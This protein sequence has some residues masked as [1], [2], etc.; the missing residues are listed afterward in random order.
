[1]NNRFQILANLAV[2]LIE[3][4]DKFRVVGLDISDII[5]S[6]AS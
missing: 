3:L 6:K 5:A 4:V 1:M 2:F